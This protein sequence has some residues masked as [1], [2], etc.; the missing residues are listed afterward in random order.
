VVPVRQDMKP[1]AKD[2]HHGPARLDAPD[3]YPSAFGSDSQQVHSFYAA[4]R[5]TQ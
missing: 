5:G 1:A 4:L 3:L 2:G